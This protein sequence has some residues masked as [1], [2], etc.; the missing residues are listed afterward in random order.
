MRGAEGL[1][2]QARAPES[3][4]LKLRIR[5]RLPTAIEVLEASAS[6]LARVSAAST[7]TGQFRRLLVF[8][9]LGSLLGPV[10]G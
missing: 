2:V 6:T 5:H 1:A 7:G 4:H 10:P 8:E 9:F 3:D